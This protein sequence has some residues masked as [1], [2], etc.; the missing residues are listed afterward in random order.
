MN[1]RLTSVVMGA[2]L[3]LASTS[4]VG[5]QAVTPAGN[6]GSIPEATFGGSGI[7]NTGMM[8]GSQNG[9]TIGLTTTRRYTSVAV[10]T[11]DGAGTYYASSG[12]STGAPTPP[13]NV[14]FATWNFDYF[15]GGASSNDYFT[16]FVDNNPASGN[17]LGDLT[18]FSWTGNAQD[19]SNLGWGAGFDP[20]ANGEY[21]FALYQYSDAARTNVV[22]HVAMNV[23]VTTTPEPSS[24]ALLGTGFVGLVG[25]VKR[26]S[27]RA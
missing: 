9:V 14:G 18:Q 26:R 3:T 27:R 21:S 20:Y 19:S 12:I 25:F 22:D 10:P 6:F 24:L 8:V 15:V 23:E 5:A 4:M 13:G 2:A 1:R 11:T 17:S 7:P 16:L